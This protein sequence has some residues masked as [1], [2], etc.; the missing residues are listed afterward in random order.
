[1]ALRPFDGEVSL[2]A[3]VGRATLSRLAR[4]FGRNVGL[5]VPP[6]NSRAHV[7]WGRWEGAAPGYPAAAARLPRSP[8][9]VEKRLADSRHGDGRVG[10][11]SRSP[12]ATL[13]RR[14]RISAG[15]QISR[16]KAI[17]RPCAASSLGKI[18]ISSEATD[19][20]RAAWSRHDQL[21]IWETLAAIV[22]A[23]KRCRA[24]IL[25]FCRHQACLTCTA[26]KLEA[27]FNSRSISSID[28]PLVSMP[29]K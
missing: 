15:L 6:T 17:G 24:P 5:V 28:L 16:P 2:V 21:A 8:H 1:M 7:P 20:E 27:A 11:L 19:A 26:A 4:R 12:L 25:L 18:P 13:A 10:A 3:A 29:R 14:S 23:S 22:C 9:N